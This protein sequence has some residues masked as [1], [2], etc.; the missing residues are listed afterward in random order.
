MTAAPIDM[1][2]DAIRLH[3]D[4]HAEAGPRV[5]DLGQDGWQ[6]VAVHAKTDV[7]VHADHWEVHNDAEEVVLCQ[8]GGIRVYLRGER[9]G[10]EEEVKL[11]AGAAVIVPRGRWHRIELDEPSDILA[12]TVLRGT[13]LERRTDG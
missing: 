13:D 10:E 11:A 8:L 2:S 9:P 5:L 12:I 4:G 7:D 3:H 1:Y 6:M